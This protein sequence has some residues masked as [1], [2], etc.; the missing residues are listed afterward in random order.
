MAW[1]GSKVSQQYTSDLIACLAVMDWDA[2]TQ[3]IAF[4]NNAITPDNTVSA[5][6]FAY[7]AGQWANT[8]EVTSS[9]DIP[10]GGLTVAT[11]T[12]V[13]SGGNVTISSASPASGA[14]ATAT[15]YGHLLYDS[16]IASPVAKQVA[17]YNFYGGAVTVTAGTLTVVPNAN[18]WMR[19]AH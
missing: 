2:D 11:K 3:K 19:Y 10:A 18:G 14:A 13:A 17:C 15:V 1:S 6:N 5:A 7:N 16:T 9:T 8:N 4:Y 12:N